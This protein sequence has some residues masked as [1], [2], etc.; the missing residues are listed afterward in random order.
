MGLIL[1]RKALIWASLARGCPQLRGEPLSAQQ[2]PCHPQHPTHHL[3]ALGGPGVAQ[4]GLDDEAGLPHPGAQ[5]E[6]GGST[7]AVAA[8]NPRPLCPPGKAP[9]FCSSPPF[10]APPPIN[11]PPPSSQSRAF[12]PRPA[13]VPLGCPACQRQPYTDVLRHDLPIFR[14]NFFP[15]LK[16]AT[17]GFFLLL[18]SFFQIIS[19]RKEAA[20]ASVSWFP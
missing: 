4:V 13:A 20:A 3:L 19:C 15:L 14:P 17:E 12:L 18:L 7:R 2:E 16:N 10:L 5:L 8:R 6:P 11:V 1:G 9:R